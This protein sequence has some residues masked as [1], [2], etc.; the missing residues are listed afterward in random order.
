MSMTRV[1]ALHSLR[2]N[3]EWVLHGDELEWHDKIQTQPI[4][5]DIQVE[6]TRLQTEWDSNKTMRDWKE[7]MAESDSSMT[8]M[9]EDFL[10]LNGTDGWPQVTK[11]RHI[12]KVALR[13]T[14]PE[15]S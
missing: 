3:A 2:P 11:D 1:D 4:D 12:S 9:W 7:K 13:A 14:K 10:T 6:I 15:A 5:A 8:R